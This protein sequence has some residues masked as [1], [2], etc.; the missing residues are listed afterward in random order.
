MKPKG[1]TMR[2][3]HRKFV[4]LIADREGDGRKREPRMTRPEKRAWTRMMKL[5][6]DYERRLTAWREAGRP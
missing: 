1:K 5:K 4:Q 2:N 6:A 3:A